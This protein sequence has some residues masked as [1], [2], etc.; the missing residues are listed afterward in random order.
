MSMKGLAARAFERLGGGGDEEDMA[1]VGG[2][3]PKGDSA[4]AMDPELVAAGKFASA[5]K[6]GD[7]SKIRDAFKDMYEAC[8]G[9]GEDSEEPPADVDYGEDA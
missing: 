6:T 7:K 8:Y 5:V 9:T 4:S 2:D 1:D 3:V